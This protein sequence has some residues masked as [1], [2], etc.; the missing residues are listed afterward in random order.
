MPAQ[1]DIHTG[2]KS[3]LRYLLKSVLKLKGDALSER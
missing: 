3:V 1:I 2:T